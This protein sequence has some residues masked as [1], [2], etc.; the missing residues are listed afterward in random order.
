[1]KVIDTADWKQIDHCT[2]S[3]SDY[4]IIHRMDGYYM[5]TVPGGDAWMDTS[6]TDIDAVKKWANGI[7]EKWC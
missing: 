3:K 2:W 7:I 4:L 5:L 6:L 1:M